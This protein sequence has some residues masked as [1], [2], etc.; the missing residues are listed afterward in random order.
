MEHVFGTQLIGHNGPVAT[1]N[2]TFRY[3]LVYFSAKWCPL[4]KV[5][6][7]QLASFYSL[8]NS[9]EQIFEVLFVSYDRNKSDFNEYFN[10]MPW[11]AV[12]Y[13]DR[14]RIGKLEKRFGVHDVPFL[15]LI[16]DDGNIKSKDAKNDI[17]TKGIR[18][19]NE[20]D[21]ALYK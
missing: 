12:K 13:E 17:I 8:V 18:A 20:W 21:A 16:D 11:L 7:S 4:C 14:K 1:S 5:F 3:K 6:T 2:V 19:L 10:E 9:Y 15:A